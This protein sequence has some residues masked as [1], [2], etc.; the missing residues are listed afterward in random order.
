[1]TPIRPLMDTACVPGERI[2]QVGARGG[3][4][5]RTLAYTLRGAWGTDAAVGP[6]VVPRGGGPLMLLVHGALNVGDFTFFDG[7]LRAA[8]IRGVCPTLPGWGNS[9][10]WPVPGFP[11]GYQEDVS[12]LL[13]AL[14]ENGPFDILG[15]SLGS[16]P[17]LA[18]AASLPGT[19]RLFVLGAFVPLALK[20]DSAPSVPEPW[21][22]LSFI[23]Y[24][25]F[26]P[27]ALSWAR[28]LGISA[29]ACWH[30]RRALVRNT[31]TSIVC[32]MNNYLV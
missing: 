15:I 19:R 14:G 22:H 9:S 27:P 11:S 25:L 18:L 3:G 20:S 1:M 4:P 10:P 31:V 17:A 5:P 26:G 21:R 6:P 23:N 30:L 29:C 7:I 12:E 13:E 28:W 24:V 8:T 32:I 2:L 16:V